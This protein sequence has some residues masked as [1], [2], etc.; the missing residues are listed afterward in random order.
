[1]KITVSTME[2][3]STACREDSFKSEEKP[4]LHSYYGLLSQTDQH[5]ALVHY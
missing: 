5:Q 3:I 4:P 1:M 2:G